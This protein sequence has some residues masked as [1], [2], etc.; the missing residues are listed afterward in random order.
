ML[1][2]HPGV[3]LIDCNDCQKRLYDL[4]SGK[5]KTYK[6]GPHREETY[7]WFEG[8]PK[9]PCT[10]DEGCPKKSPREAHQFELSRRGWETFE[11]WKRY[12]AAPAA[13][14]VDELAAAAFAVLDNLDREY[15]AY[16]EAER[17]QT[18]MKLIR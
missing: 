5:P 16:L 8:K 10:T 12:R 9:P 1:L 11:A 17:L 15:S 4:R 6:S 2:R 14:E 13:F 18:A 7:Y 3:A